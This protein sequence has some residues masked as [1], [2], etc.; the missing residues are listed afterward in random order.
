M[1]DP[2]TRICKHCR[3]SCHQ[4]ICDKQMH[5][6]SAG[7]HNS[8]FVHTG[9]RS[10]VI[11]NQ[12]L[13]LCQHIRAFCMYLRDLQKLLRRC[14]AKQIAKSLLRL[15]LASRN[16][17][18]ANAYKQNHLFNRHGSLQRCSPPS[19][20]SYVTFLNSYSLFHF[21]S[22]AKVSYTT[23]IPAARNSGRYSERSILLSFS[24]ISRYLYY[25]ARSCGLRRRIRPD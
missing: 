1:I 19:V 21:E 13:S 4:Y 6:I 20:R 10:H 23:K 18:Y 8:F 9:M 15:R 24:L 7:S 11:N 17:N 5:S 3:Y 12:P 22:Q 25:T 2:R 14:S 16:D